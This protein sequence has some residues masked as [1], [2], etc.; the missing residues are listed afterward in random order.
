MSAILTVTDRVRVPGDTIPPGVDAVSWRRTAD[1]VWKYRYHATERGA[2]MATTRN[3][4]AYDRHSYVEWGWKHITL[5][6][7][8]WGLWLW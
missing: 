6:D 8:R 2:K 1:N 5:Q 3:G 4:H 7:R